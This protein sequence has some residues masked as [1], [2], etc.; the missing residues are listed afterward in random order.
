MKQINTHQMRDFAL[1][2]KRMTD[3]VQKAK[4][5]KIVRCDEKVPEIFLINSLIDRN[6]KN[7]NKMIDNVLYNIS[8]LLT[9]TGF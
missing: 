8:L 1:P 6:C 7:I 5:E 2:L 4:V 9:M 3:E